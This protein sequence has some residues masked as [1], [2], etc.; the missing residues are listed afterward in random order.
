MEAV[1]PGKNASRNARKRAK[2]R[3]RRRLQATGVEPYPASSG[4]DSG[5]PSRERARGWW[6][7]EERCGRL[8]LCRRWG[9][10]WSGVT[11]L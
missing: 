10:R 1:P 11:S 6:S 4:N 9:E 3:E 8:R 7:G 2:E 5:A